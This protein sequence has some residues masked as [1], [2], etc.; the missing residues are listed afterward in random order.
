LIITAATFAVSLAV[1]NAIK[2][3][4][5]LRVTR[6]GEMHGLDLHEHGISAYPE[7]LISPVARPR[8]M[9]IEEP[10]SL[11]PAPAAQLSISES[12]P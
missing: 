6:E 5:L 2:G 9:T 1:M 12:S 8:G 10:A 3:V 11:N 7:Y 4:G